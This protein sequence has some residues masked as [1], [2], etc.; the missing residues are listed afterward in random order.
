[1][2]DP[3]RIPALELDYSD[4]KFRAEPKTVCIG[5]WKPTTLKCQCGY[6][7]GE[8][9]REPGRHE[10]TCRNCRVSAAIEVYY[11]EIE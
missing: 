8:T 4:D 1:M 7:I 9:P 6:V 11:P 5:R 10:I 2:S 3:I